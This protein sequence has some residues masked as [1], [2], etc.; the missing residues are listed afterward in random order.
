M[1]QDERRQVDEVFRAR[2]EKVVRLP[3]VELVALLLHCHAQRR[4][5]ITIDYD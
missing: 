2:D 3:Q 5:P 1:V 4:R